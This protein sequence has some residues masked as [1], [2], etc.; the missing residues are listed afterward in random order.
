MERV[1]ISILQNP[2]HRKG[3]KRKM[4][5]QFN[6]IFLQALETHLEKIQKPKN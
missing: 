4:K 3:I 6:L 5:N 2:K 1:F